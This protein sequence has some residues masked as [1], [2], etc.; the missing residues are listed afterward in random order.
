MADLFTSLVA[1]APGV[2]KVSGRQAERA[3]G[4]SPSVKDGIWSE[5]TLAAGGLP[6]YG[7]SAGLSAYIQGHF[8]NTAGLSAILTTSLAANLVGYWALDGNSTALVGSATGTDS[9]VSYA[10]AKINSGAVFTGGASRISLTGGPAL[11]TV[12]SISAWLFPTSNV[13]T[14][15]AILSRSGVATGLFRK[16]TTKLSLYDAGDHLSTGNVTISIWTHIVLTSDGTSIRFYLN[17]T[18]DTTTVY[19]PTTFTVGQ[20]GSDTSNEGFIGTIDEVG[21]W[22][23]ALS[24]PEIT[25]LYNVGA[26]RQYP[27]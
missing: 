27:F 23:R 7:T 3:P 10:A 26:G 4:V 15:G 18:L 9:S 8:E 19:V 21:T 16:S 20:I 24:G 5:R 6:S 17:G 25:T 14:Y 22:T 13:P 12:F 11:G 1:I 2:A